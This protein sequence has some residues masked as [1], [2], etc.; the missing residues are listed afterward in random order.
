MGWASVGEPA[1]ERLLDRRHVAGGHQRGCHVRS[2]ELPR[3]TVAN[4][5]PRDVDAELAQPIDDCADAGLPKRRQLGERAHE[6]LRGCRV[7]VPEQVHGA[8]SHLRRELD[9]RDDGDAVSRTGGN[10]RRHSVDGVVIGH[11]QQRHPGG[12]RVG[13]E[14]TRCE[15]AVGRGRMGVEVDQRARAAGIGNTAIGYGPAMTPNEPSARAT[16][17]YSS[18]SGRVTRPTAK[19][20]TAPPGDGIV[21]VSRTKTGRG[22]KTVTLVSGLPSGVVDATAKELKR[23]CGTGGTAKDGVVE[24]QGDH[25]ERIVAHLSERYRTKLAGG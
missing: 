19:R 13:D 9:A 24:I 14:L 6:R 12:G 22:G 3:G 20:A 25:R 17:V 4:R 7:E 11:R 5:F 15:V 1:V 23:L 2:T 18:E 8:V 21:R 10:G 16:R